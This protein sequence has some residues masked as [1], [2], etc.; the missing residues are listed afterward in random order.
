M[1]QTFPKA[2]RLLKKSE[3]QR[4]Y[5][6][7]TKLFGNQILIY[8]STNHQQ[9]N[10]IGISVPKRFGKAHDRNY[11]KR[12]MRESFRTFNFSNKSYDFHVVPKRIISEMEPK[13][14]K[15]EFSQLLEKLNL[16]EYHP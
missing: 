3:F 8:A 16:I 11:F 5:H 10:R 9:T 1:S 12:L 6:K 14:L 2:S 4:V 13:A 7:G 15:E